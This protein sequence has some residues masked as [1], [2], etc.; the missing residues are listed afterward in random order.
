MRYQHASELGAD[1]RQIAHPSSPLAASQSPTRKPHWL[2]GSGRASIAT[3]ESGKFASRAL[4]KTAQQVSSGRRVEPWA[5]AGVLT[6]LL[7]IALWAL[8]RPLRP[9][10]MQ[11]VRLDVDLG[12]ELSLRPLGFPEVGY[13]SSVVISPDGKRVAYVASAGGGPLKLFTRRLDQPKATELPGTEGVTFCFSRRM[14]SG[15][16]SPLSTG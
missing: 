7:A 5:V 16:G 6:V 2:F 1:L 4:S 8:C 11:L 15:L 9:V 12:S 3:E 10:E 13:T 14:A